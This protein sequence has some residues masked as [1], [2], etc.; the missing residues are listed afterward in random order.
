MQ[1]L[2]DGTYTDVQAQRGNGV[3]HGITWY[4]SAFAIKSGGNKR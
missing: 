1:M 3:A 2:K 4:I